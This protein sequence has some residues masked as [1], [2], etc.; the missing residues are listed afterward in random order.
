MH[1]NINNTGLFI[2]TNFIKADDHES[3]KYLK[4]TI[5]GV[6]NQTDDNWQICIIDDC[7]SNLDAIDY[8]ENIRIKNPDRV[9]V[10]FLD[11]NVGPGLARNLG[12]IK[13]KKNEHPFVLF[14]DSDDISHPERL[15]I[16]RK[17]FSSMPEID[18]IYSTFEVIDENNVVRPFAE[19]PSSIQEI[20]EF[21]QKKQFLEG[22]DV[23]VDMCTKTGY[24]NKTSAT[25]IRTS[26]AIN[27]PFPNARASEDFN[28]WI[29]ISAMGAYFK[30]ISA[31]PTLYRV[32]KYLKLQKSRSELGNNAFNKIKIKM[33]TEGF[34]HAINIA[35]SK[36]KMNIQLALE[37][38]KSFYFRLAESMK[39]EKEEELEKMLLK[40]IED[41]DLSLY[42][43]CK[44][45]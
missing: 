9:E 24:M 43:Y 23:W 44:D 21:H 4:Q 27:C 42:I 33:D 25:S 12:L 7:S 22:Y 31:I 19:I 10:T 13:A 2:I 45:H 39:R 32:P 34:E 14:N 35:F 37:L 29:R 15:A 36:N 30:Y 28:T 41:C 8:L 1:D 5:D 20:L 11:Q 40:M 38:K 6:F 17:L 18:L 16:T 3:I 26:M